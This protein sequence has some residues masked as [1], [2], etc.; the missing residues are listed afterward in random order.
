MERITFAV[1]IILGIVLFIIEA[2]ITGPIRLIMIMIA[3]ILLLFGIVGLLH[4]WEKTRKLFK[5]KS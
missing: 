2:L 1:F 4:Y 5:M 3:L